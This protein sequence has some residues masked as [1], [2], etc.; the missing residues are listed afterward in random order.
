MN[1]SAMAAASAVVSCFL[2][3]CASGTTPASPGTV[4]EL[5]RQYESIKRRECE[6]RE[7]AGWQTD[8]R[9]VADRQSKASALLKKIRERHAAELAAAPECLHAYSVPEEVLAREGID[10]DSPHAVA[11]L[12]T[13]GFMLSEVARNEACA[14]EVC[15]WRR[16]ADSESA[17]AF[18]P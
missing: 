12:L 6:R 5:I 7:F 9:C 17:S 1:P 10:A 4:P 16:Q 8:M 18:C 2:A 14:A 13:R 15:R 11:D 3:G